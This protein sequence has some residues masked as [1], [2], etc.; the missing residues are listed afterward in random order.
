MN[1][2]T[3]ASAC[4]RKA[5]YELLVLEKIEGDGYE[6]RIKLL[7]KK[8]P[9]SDP[10]LFDIMA[11][12]QDM[13]SDK[14]HEQSWDKWDSPHLKLMIETLKTVLYDIYVMPALKKERSLNIQRLQE[15]IK[16]DKVKGP[17]KES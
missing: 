10:S 5:I 1:F 11:Q 9:G 6:S 13:T 12:I 17:N 14:I 4:A 3:G 7:K 15:T 8:Y 16:Q 2:L